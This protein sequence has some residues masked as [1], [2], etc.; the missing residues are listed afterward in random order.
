MKKQKRTSLAQEVDRELIARGRG[1]IQEFDTSAGVSVSAR[2]RESRLISI[3]LPVWMIEKLQ[4]VAEV[5]GN[6]GYQQLIKI[7]LANALSEGFVKQPFVSFSFGDTQGASVPVV[8]A[9]QKDY[10]RS[11]EENKLLISHTGE[12]SQLNLGRE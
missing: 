7:F 3:R 6:V 2:S 12:G 5:K 9:E 8:V 11:K 4:Q 1:V 10:A